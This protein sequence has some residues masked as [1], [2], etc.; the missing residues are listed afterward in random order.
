MYLVTFE[1][2]EKFFASLFQ[3][4]EAVYDKLENEYLP[5][6]KKSKAYYKLLQELD[7]IQQ[8]TT[9]EDALSLNSNDSL[10]NNDNASQSLQSKKYEFLSVNS[11][12]KNI[13]HVRSFSDVSSV[14]G[15]TE[16]ETKSRSS[17]HDKRFVVSCNNNSQER[18]NKAEEGSLKTGDFTL[19]VTVIETGIVCE[20]GKTFGIYAIRVGRQYETGYQEE[21]HI[22]R[23]YSDF[24]DLYSKV[25]E[26]VRK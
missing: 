22:Y 7:L 25:K 20:K 2:R 24:Y 13:K 18:G 12:P 26:K 4:L 16:V 8:P 21:W 9:E 15:K 19:T 5:L 3:V 17:S 6:F 14:I 23:R 10:E 11:S 1:I